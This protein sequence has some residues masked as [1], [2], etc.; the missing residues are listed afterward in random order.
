MKR[1]LMIFILVISLCSVAQA[2]QISKDAALKAI[3]NFENAPLGDDG[4]DAAAI[5]T[6]FATESKEVYITI[7]MKILTWLKN[8]DETD[9]YYQFRAVLLAAYLSGNVKSQLIQ[10][11][12]KDDPYAGLLQVLR[13]YNQLKIADSGFKL[14]EIETLQDL[15]NNNRLK[16]H[17]K[18]VLAQEEQ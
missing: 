12:A 16:A 15:K 6:R 8:D 13:T 1:K 5:I 2:G 9:P 10:G 7:S 4:K 17:I 14:S 11:A 3:A 18:E